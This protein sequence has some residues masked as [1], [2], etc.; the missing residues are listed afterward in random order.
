MVYF[1]S[2]EWV[3]QYHSPQWAAE[4]HS[5]QWVV[6]FHSP[7]IGGS[8][9]L[10]TMGGLVLPTTAGLQIAGCQWPK[11]GHILEMAGEN[12]TGLPNLKNMASKIQYMSLMSVHLI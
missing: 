6:Q 11:E 4:F 8:V 7:Q 10:T 9:S 5:P 2:P 3:V 12:K 1:H